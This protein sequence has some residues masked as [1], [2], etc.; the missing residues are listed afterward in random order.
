MNELEKI[1]TGNKK[2]AE[3]LKQLSG[4]EDSRVAILA[5]IYI[6]V[7][8]E[9]R[10]QNVKDVRKDIAY[11]AKDFGQLPEK[12]VGSMNSIVKS[13]IEEIN[14]LM[15]IYNDEFINIHNTLYS[16]EEEQKTYF[17]KLRET[18]VMKNV[19]ILAEKPKEEYEFL[20]KEILDYK[21]KLALYERVIA[22]CDKEFEACKNRRENDFKELFEI[23]QEQALAV[24]TKENLFSKIIKKIRNKFHGY[25]S[26]SKNVLQKHAARINKMK[27]ETVNLYINNVKQDIVNFSSE[28]DEMVENA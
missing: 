19:C 6:R 18:T 3:N 22:R 9:L 10:L 4:T 21:K 17:F 26:F 2:L 8:D 24:I 11:G 25:E 15:K 20:D 1:K 28:I 14:R 5:A 12:Y 13:Y 27:T 16:A 7:N 23:K